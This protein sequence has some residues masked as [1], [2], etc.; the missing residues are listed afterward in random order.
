MDNLIFTGKKRYIISQIILS[1]F[2]LLGALGCVML[3]FMMPEVFSLMLLAAAVCAGFGYRIVKHIIRCITIS[4]GTLYQEGYN[5]DFDITIQ[6]DEVDY[7]L[8]EYNERVEYG[9]TDNIVML[10]KGKTIIHK[11]NTRM[12]HDAEEFKK[13][14]PWPKNGEYKRDIMERMWLSNTIKGKNIVKASMDAN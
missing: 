2:C 6:P 5:S 9:I 13:V 4:D 3:M 14:L 1:I 12:I 10:V 8:E 11:I 7:W